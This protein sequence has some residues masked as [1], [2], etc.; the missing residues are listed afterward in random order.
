VA[1]VA[2]IVTGRWKENCYVVAGPGGDAIV[3]D[4]GGELAQIQAHVVERDLRVHA[5]LNTHAHYDHLGAVV[6][7]VEQYGAPFHLHPA[8]EDLLRRAN[9]YRRLFLGEESIRIPSVDRELADGE[10]L[11]F[12][13]LEVGVVHTPGHTPGSVCFE[14]DG[15]LF[16]G[17]TV[18]AK[19]LGRTDLPGGDRD[20]LMASVALIAERYP[21]GT[22]LSP[23][24]GE[25]AELGEVLSR[26]GGLPEFRG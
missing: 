4:P 25:A 24:H 26:L 13:S 3:I 19:H 15:E 10:Q 5:V 20:L 7:V 16:T 22:R 21:E 17:D 6:P 11:S 8:D 9:F 2:R 12:G 14:C 18:M 1:D 23:G